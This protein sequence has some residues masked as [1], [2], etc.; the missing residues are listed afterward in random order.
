VQ[1]AEPPLGERKARMSRRFL[2][3][4]ECMVEMASIGGDT[5][6]QGFA[7]DSFN[8]AWYARRALPADWD[9]DYFT[10]LGDDA[11]SGRMLRFMQ[12]QGIGI[13]H[14]H[15]L[16]GRAPGLYMIELENGERSFTYWRDTSAARSLADDAG[17]LFAALAQADA[18]YVSGITLAILAPD[19]RRT[20][21]DGLGRAKAAGKMV[22]F[23]SNIR[24]RLWPNPHDLRAAIKDAAR[25]ATI[26]LPTI[27]DESDL[28][29]ETSAEEVW[30][31]YNEY[32]CNEVVVRAGGGP[33]HVV[34][35]GKVVAVAPNEVVAPVDTTGAGDSFN[36]TYLAARLTGESPEAAARKAH[37]VAGKVIR[38]Y[39][40]LVDPS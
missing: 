34:W 30:S 2:S 32:G 28:F 35:G 4:G 22:G 19:R 23:D 27:P 16:A 3:I 36:G 15:R 7:G 39:G 21:L 1:A 24:M 18:I 40:A 29:G 9:V 37:A 5:F 33:A 6:R 31:R 12:D 10:T 26:S 20:L 17:A 38:H 14:I 8:T 11:V 13:G 25:V